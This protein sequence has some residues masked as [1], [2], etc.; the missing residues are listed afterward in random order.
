[1]PLSK[2]EIARKMEELYQMADDAIRAGQNPN[3]MLNRILRDYNHLLL[4]L[5]DTQERFTER[6]E[7]LI[8]LEEQNR[9]LRERVDRINREVPGFDDEQIKMI[10]KENSELKREKL[11]LRDENIRL[12]NEL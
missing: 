6:D 10:I 3:I 5:F 9:T 8:R 1:M 2:E 7:L 12:G 4:D 11:K